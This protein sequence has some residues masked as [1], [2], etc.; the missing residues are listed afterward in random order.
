[1][2]MNIPLKFRN[3]DELISCVSPLA[4]S[5][6]QESSVGSSSDVIYKLQYFMFS[7]CGFK[8]VAMPC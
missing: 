4:L 1:M 7:V 5:Q 8:I 2:K 3:Y 6:K